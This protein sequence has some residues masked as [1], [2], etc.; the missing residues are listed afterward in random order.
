MRPFSGAGSQPVRRRGIVRDPAVDG[1]L[2]LLRDGY[3]FV[4]DRCDRL[5][6]DVF[7]TRLLGVRTLC[8]RGAEPAR[9]F[10]DAAR[11]R[12][13]GATPARVRNTLTGRGGVQG[14]D[15]EAHRHR[16]AMFMSLMTPE[17]IAALVAATASEWRRAG[18]GRPGDRIVLF[19]RAERALCRAVC[20]WSG[21]PL[22]EQHAARRTADFD[23]MIGGGA[24]LGMRYWY[25]RRA[26]VRAE[27]WIAGLVEQV[28]AARLPVDDT[29]ALAVIAA[30]R[31]PAGRP[32]PSRIA[33]VEVLNVLRPTVAVATYATF[34]ALA[35]H[36]YPSARE[37]VALDEGW[38]ERFV[39]EVRR[40]YPFFPFAAA[41]VRE[42]FEW[43]GHSLPRG[44]RVLLD[45][46]ATNHDAA[47]GDPDAFRPDRFLS[48]HPGPYDFVPQGGGD[49]ATQH[50]CAGERVTIELLKSA[51]RFLSEELV[52]RVPAQNLY[53][54]LRRM[55]T[56][57]RSGFV[58]ELA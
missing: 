14:L 47:W 10:Y 43:R 55:P 7:E 26:R 27:R 51:V 33:A 31:D 35:L 28:R 9:L 24:A 44:R 39:H 37:A 13:E 15:G 45:L 41:R 6:T 52:Y 38:L 4:R 50:R 23:A 19:D 3:A 32:L 11:M 12:R 53:V 57:P 34:A 40:F 58:I 18:H 36:E 8:M 30:H 54:S 42:P 17:R 5:G 56:R 48:L 29:A 49:H 16:K 22:P 25:A 1:T 20:A 2:G 21:V 46:Y